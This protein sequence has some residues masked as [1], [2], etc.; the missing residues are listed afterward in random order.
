MMT[1]WHFIIAAYAVTGLG[2]FGLLFASLMAM[3]QAEAPNAPP[4]S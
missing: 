2:T 1:H 4:E 3:R